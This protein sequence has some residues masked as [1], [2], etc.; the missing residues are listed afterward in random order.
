M[1]RGNKVRAA[2]DHGKKFRSELTSS[3]SSIVLIVVSQKMQI[4]LFFM[5]LGAYY[6]KRGITNSA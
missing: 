1:S 4:K 5:Q 2:K 6:G 3:S